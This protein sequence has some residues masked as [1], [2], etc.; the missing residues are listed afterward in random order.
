[1]SDKLWKAFERWVGQYIFGGA[2]RNPGSG[3]NNKDDQGNPRPGDVIHEM[4]QVECKVYKAIAI[5]RW[6][7][8]LKEEAKQVGKIPVLVMREKGDAQDTLVTIHY[9]FFNELKEVW[10]KER[11]L[12]GGEQGSDQRAD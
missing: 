7:D 9:T 12:I 1:M 6:W 2:K 5:F 11:G 10:E 3:K 4:Y 8:K